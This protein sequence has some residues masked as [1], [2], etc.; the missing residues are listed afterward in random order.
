MSFGL[1]YNPTE[2]N[3]FTHSVTNSYMSLIES[4]PSMGNALTFRA[5]HPKARPLLTEY[6]NITFH[7]LIL[8]PTHLPMQMYAKANFIAIPLDE[9][10]NVL[11][12]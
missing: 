10:H 3:R 12:N 8:Q 7:R 6:Q 1:Q 5:N 11:S 4:S 2:E 9:V